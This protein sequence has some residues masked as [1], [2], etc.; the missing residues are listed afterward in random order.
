M[1][2]LTLHE[3][4]VDLMKSELLKRQ[5]SSTSSTCVVSIQPPI[6]TDRNNIQSSS[7]ITKSILSRCFDTPIRNLTSSPRL[8]QELEEYLSTD[9][10]FDEDDDVLFFWIHQKSKFPSL[11]SIVKDFYTI[12]SSNTVVERLFSTS[13]NN[14]SDKRTSL[15]AQK[16]NKLLFL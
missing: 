3:K 2:T 11:F 10:Q 12:T 15:N 9:F 13:K 4:A 1:A 14:I 5:S 7:S 16:V 8:Y 6:R